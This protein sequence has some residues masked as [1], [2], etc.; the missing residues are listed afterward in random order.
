MLRLECCSRFCK[1]CLCKSFKNVKN[2][3]RLVDA[4]HADRW[5]DKP[6]REDEQIKGQDGQTE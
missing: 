3:K 6:E 4:G 2:K 5:N 1:F